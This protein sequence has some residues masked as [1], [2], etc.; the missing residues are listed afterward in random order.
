MQ[1]G[2]ERRSVAEQVNLQTLFKTARQNNGLMGKPKTLIWEGS[3][4]S[5]K[6]FFATSRDGQ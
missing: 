1:K 3:R 6:A 2:K 5:I 4:P